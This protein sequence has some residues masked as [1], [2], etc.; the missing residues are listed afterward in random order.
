[1][2]DSRFPLILLSCAALILTGCSTVPASLTHAENAVQWQPWEAVLTARNEHPRAYATVDVD[3]RFTGPDGATFSVP[4]FWDGDRT[5]RFRAAFPSAGTWRWRTTCNDPSDAGLDGIPGEV[6]VSAYPGENPLYRHG[7]LRVSADHRYLIH[8]DGTPFLWMGDTAWNAAW[9]STP[10]E[11]REY[12]DRR[13]GQ[14]FSVLQV[15]AT[16]MVG[17]NSQASPPGGHPPFLSDGTPNALFWRGLEE[18]ISYANERGLIVMLVGVGESP[19]G[20]A[21]SQRPVAFARYL[22]GR[23]AGH[24]V[25]LSPSM[26]QRF[27]EQNDEAG[28]TLHALTTHLVTQ[29]P[30]THLPTILRYHDAAYTDFCGLQSG[31]R[32]GDLQLAYQGAREWALELWR[33]PPVKP[34][35]HLEAMYDAHGHNFAPAWREQDVR[36][37]GWIGWL[38]GARGYTY[39]AGD[40]P[41]KVIGAG[42]GIWR[43]QVDPKAYDYWRTA[44][45]WPSAGQMTRL[46]D[47]LAGIDWWRLAPAPDLV[48][49]QAGEQTR[50]MVVSRSATGDLLVAYLPDNPEI[51]LDLRGLVPG[52]K[53]TWY[54]PVTGRS[55]ALKES[56]PAD[57]IATFHRPDDWN[58]AVLLL[59]RTPPT[60]PRELK[61]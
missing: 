58:D 57:S 14:R 41:P 44:M 10:A 21:A 51:A 48:R 60:S 4:A 37:L 54:N 33:R 18:K 25:I 55:T 9:K 7:D 17:P 29:H 12:V 1:M 53:G 35:I 40:I 36:K 28:A 15:V 2:D 27:S 19:A 20:F 6:Q 52:L 3:V 43:F 45:N 39:G 8:A 61:P 16:G 22:A 50:K 46:R 49:N 26:D 23:L 24:L 38:S 30:G 42:G 59:T 11:W 32:N 34:V 13:A 5:F 31:H 56:I 47:F